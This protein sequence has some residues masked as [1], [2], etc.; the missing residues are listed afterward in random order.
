[1][2]AAF[3]GAAFILKIVLHYTEIVNNLYSQASFREN[4]TS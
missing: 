1:M 3:S 4:M 2:G